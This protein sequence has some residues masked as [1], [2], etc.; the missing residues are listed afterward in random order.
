MQRGERAR[1]IAAFVLCP[2]LALWSLDRAILGWTAQWQWVSEHVPALTFDPYRAEAILRTIPGAGRSVP[3]LGNSTA[4]FAIDGKR[5][6]QIFSEQGLLFPKV[7]IGNSSALTF[8]MLA[9][10]ICGLAPPMAIFVST[11]PI[12]LGS[13]I[14]YAR[15]FSY[16]PFAAPALFD[17]REALDH[18]GFHFDGAISSLHILARHRSAI[19][20]TLLVRAGLADWGDLAGFDFRRRMAL[21]LQDAL[22]PPEELPLPPPIHDR[23]P[24]PNSRALGYLAEC[25][26]AQGGRLLVVPSPPHPFGQMLIS[27]S[28]QERYLVELAELGRAHGFDWVAPDEL[29]DFEESDFSDWLHATMEGRDTYTRF[30]VPRIRSTLRRTGLALQ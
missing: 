1:L 2:I 4:E 14:D 23:Y 26:T 10:S 11:G 15:V 12:S 21:A 20:R 13:E 30:L 16:D 22:A 9:R 17:L 24:N 25:L 19:Q 27:R 5:L 8:G 7:T 28:R 6:E 3:I 18:P 29:P